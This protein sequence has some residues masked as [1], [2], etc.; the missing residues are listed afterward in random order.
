MEFLEVRE[1][2]SF[3]GTPL[4]V[5]GQASLF[6]LA[7]SEAYRNKNK[8]I[9]KILS[10]KKSKIRYFLPKIPN[11]HPINFVSNGNRIYLFY[12]YTK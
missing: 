7:L 11:D 1:T 9:I 4:C 5:G 10:K 3:E 8:K 12:L 2:A 6:L